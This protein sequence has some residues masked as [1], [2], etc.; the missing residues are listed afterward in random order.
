MEISANKSGLLC[1]KLCGTPKA[2]FLFIVA[3]D[4]ANISESL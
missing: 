2:S 1:H 4:Q 3:D